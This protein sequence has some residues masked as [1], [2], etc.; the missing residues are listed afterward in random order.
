M[1]D[2]TP[3]FVSEMDWDKG[4]DAFPPENTGLTGDSRTEARLCAAQGLYTC[5][6]MGKD[7]RDVAAEFEPKLNKRKADKK[8]YR[9]IMAE[10]GEG[11]ER[12][13]TMLMAEV[14]DTWDWPRMD[15]VL[16]ALGLAGAAELTANPEAPVAVI[17]S[18]YLNIAKA[19]VTPEEVAYLNKSLDSI[20]KKVRG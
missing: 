19:F 17:I 9:A 3:E 15:P 11:A 8:L 5:Q 16:R 20:A 1:A 7:A 13:K 2:T 10:A 14:Q 18:E 4:E 6:V 12:Y